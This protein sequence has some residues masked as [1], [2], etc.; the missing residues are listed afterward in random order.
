MGS[1]HDI[2]SEA[3]ASLGLGIAA[4]FWAAAFIAGKVVLAEM[5]PLSVAAWRFVIAGGVLLPIAY[6]QFPG[7]QAL[8]SAARP[9][10]FMTL[11][12]GILYPWIFLA[13]LARTS[14]A[15]T[16]LLIA[17]NPI[18]TLCLSGLVGERLSARNAIG[19]AL[20][21]S[22]AA[23]VITRGD[24]SAVAQLTALNTGDL[25]ALLGAACWASFNLTSRSVAVGLPHGFVNGLIYGIGGVVLF[26][27]ASAE[28]PVQQLFAAS[29][30]ALA[31]LCL[32]AIVS[33]VI[34]GMLF[35]HGIRTLG[36]NR[37]VLF[38]YLVPPLTALQ[39]VLLLGETLHL[40]QLAGGALALAGVYWATKPSASATTVRRL[41]PASV[42]E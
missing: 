41:E 18:F 20:A 27:M 6:H 13:A 1:A 14:A 15:N 42:R 19:A 26:T 24:W 23:M 36:V 16:S 25:L 32:M 33:S 28:A 3:F 12:A 17:L 9:L 34:A 31:C 21:L 10:A 37:T 39:S 2:R 8:K 30:A 22:G 38:I 5:S 29:T 4:L 7:W 35:L 40:A 11:C